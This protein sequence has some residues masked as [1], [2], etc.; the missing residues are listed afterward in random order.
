LEPELIRS[1]YGSVREERIPIPLADIPQH[2]IDAVLSIEDQRFFDHGGLDLKRI[3]GATVAN[4][5]AAGVVQGGST[6]T[7]QLAKNLFLSNK[8][9]PIRKL[10]DMA[11]ARTLERRYTKEEILEAYLNEVYF[12]HDDGL[13]I[14]GVGRAAQYFFG[15]DVSQIDMGEAA[16]LAGII[17]GP[18]LYSP[19]RRPETATKRR[20]LVLDVMLEREIISERTHRE[21]R[22]VPLRIR[23]KTQRTRS[24]RYFVDYVSE[25]LA[26]THGRKALQRGMSV[27]TTLDM[28]LQRAAERAVVNGL[29]RLKKDY[30]YIAG[31]E[32]AL[33]AALVALDPRTGEILAM[34]GGREYGSSQFNRA[35]NARRQ[36]GSSFK[37]IVALAALS[38][39]DGHTLATVLQDEPFS[40]ETPAGLWQPANYDGEFRGGVTLREALERSLN[41]PF[42]KLGMEV[43]PERIVETGRRLGLESRLHPVPSLALGASEVTPLEMTRAFGV[44]AAGG[45]RSDVHT[46]LGVIDNEGAVVSRYEM[47]GEQVYTP[48]ETYLVTSAL[49]GAVERGTGRSLRTWGFRGPVA[50][51]SGTTNDFRDAWFIGYTPSLAVGVWVG[52]D[53]GRS[54]NL[55]GSRAALPIFASF[56]RAAVGSNGEGDFSRPSGLEV[57][58]VN[59]ETGLR[60]GYGCRGE[61]EVFLRGTAPRESCS[62]FR[63]YTSR[64]GISGSRNLTVVPPL[65]PSRRGSRSSSQH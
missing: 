37:P 63:S 56:L 10:R 39:R 4:V 48:A 20:N 8:R 42:A 22:Q 54:T 36:P 25:Q 21:A 9:S 11:M 61:Q 41:V 45:Y 34:V 17:R 14:H 24:G 18:N 53:D 19:V 62:W 55:T 32:A 26:A 23:G 64:N 29:A 31:E 59:R 30:P 7:Q 15:K 52:F 5:R 16:L 6:L 57:V 28:E 27:F 47:A 38:Q 43:G 40:V 49:R 58:S 35:V 33:Q 60:A 51:K 46:L 65:R 50:A 3:A 12:G 2:L 13:A 44:L 1:V